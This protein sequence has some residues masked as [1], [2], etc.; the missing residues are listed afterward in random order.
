[1]KEPR[2]FP[3]WVQRTIVVVVIFGGAGYIIGGM[4]RWFFQLGAG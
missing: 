3:G 1:M 2:Q 4:L